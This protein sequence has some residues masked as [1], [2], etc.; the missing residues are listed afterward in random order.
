MVDTISICGKRGL[1]DYI[2]VLSWFFKH[3]KNSYHIKFYCREDPL[4]DYSTLLP[5]LIELFQP[6]PAQL[7]TWEIDFSWST[8][9]YEEACTKF[10]INDH[11]KTWLCAGKIP[12]HSYHPLKYMW[13]GNTDSYICLSLNHEFHHYYTPYKSSLSQKFFT[14]DINNTLLKFN[15]GVNHICLGKRY[16]SLKE[17]IILMSGCQY[18]LGI[19]GAW[20]HFAHAMNVPYKAVANAMG[21]DFVKSM[22]PT[23]PTL[24]IIHT[25]ELFDYLR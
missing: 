1:G 3:F 5:S 4:Y 8:V 17:D 25:Q 12:D 18:V 9:S 11:L 20:T 21:Y 23:H 22:H 24:K 15:D 2:Q 7:I 10:D 16:R 14:E 19:E 6:E 13:Q